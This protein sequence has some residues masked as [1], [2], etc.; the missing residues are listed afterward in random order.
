MHLLPEPD[1]IDALHRLGGTPSAVL[2]HEELMQLLLPTLRADFAINETYVYTHDMPL[3]APITAFGGE[4]DDEVS[5]QDVA[6]WRTQTRSAFKLNIL[7]GKH[8]FIHNEQDLLLQLIAQDL[9]KLLSSLSPHQSP[10]SC[11]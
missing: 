10:Q 1:F 5:V 3:G 8:F 7:P 4:H 2:E 9:T 6:A 11:I